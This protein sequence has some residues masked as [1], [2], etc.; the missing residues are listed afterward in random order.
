MQTIEMQT[1]TKC[2]NLLYN[3]MSKKGA[4]FRLLGRKFFPDRSE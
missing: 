2:V 3:M 4:I 1:F